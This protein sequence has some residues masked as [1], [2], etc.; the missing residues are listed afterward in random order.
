LPLS[1][2]LLILVF[3]SLSPG[4]RGVYILPAIPLLAIAMAPLLP[5]LLKLRGLQRTAAAVLA[6]L[7]TGFL[8][9]GLL[10]LAGFDPLSRLATR[11][12]VAPW[13]W[14]VFL[15]VAALGLLASLRPCQGMLALAGWLSAFWVTWSTWG[16]VQLDPVR[17]PRDVMEQVVAV[18][19]PGAW[20]AMP[21]FDE[22]F[23]LQ[24]RQPMV[25]FGRDTPSPAQ[26]RRAFH[27]LQQAPDQRWM[28]IEQ[29]RRPDLDCAGLG[30]ARDLGFQNGDYW[31][32]IPGSAFAGCQGAEDAAPLFVAPTTVHSGGRAWDLPD[33][34][35]SEHATSRF[36]AR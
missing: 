31:W 30:A 3:F 7:G 22:E 18:T 8:V 29:N 33:T 14:W 4:K 12:G 13:Y 34:R 6:V 15:G 36:L 25:H 27:W 1:G 16:Y 32:L 10:G 9:A 21:D 26:M 35:R 19:G 20:L 28:L 5:G 23:L 24:A 17:S 2:V 11:H